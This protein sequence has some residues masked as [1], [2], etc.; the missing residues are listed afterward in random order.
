MDRRDFLKLTAASG[1]LGLSLGSEVNSEDQGVIAQMDG[2][3]KK[4]DKMVLNRF[5][6]LDTILDN[7]RKAHVN[8]MWATESTVESSFMPDPNAADPKKRM[9][10]GGLQSVKLTD[11]VSKSEFK[12]HYKLVIWTTL[13]E[14]RSQILEQCLIKHDNKSISFCEIDL[15]E[16]KLN[17]N[18]HQNV[19]YKTT[20]SFSHQVESE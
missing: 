15:G 19:I 9:P 14:D 13:Q 5:Q 18:Y 7:G 2:I 8:V 16:Y 17:P 4:H 11:F 20:I 6:D 12:I 10:I 1:V 3:I